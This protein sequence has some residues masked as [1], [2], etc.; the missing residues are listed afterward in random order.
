MWVNVCVCVH[1][2]T[3]VFL[4]IKR[5]VFFL[6]LWKTPKTDT[7]EQALRETVELVGLVNGRKNVS[8]LF[9][10]GRNMAPICILQDQK[11]VHY[12][13]QIPLYSVP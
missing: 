4:Q 13:S 12:L 1:G 9:K 5:S 3:S 6:L 2:L 10:I 8:G 7:D 11:F